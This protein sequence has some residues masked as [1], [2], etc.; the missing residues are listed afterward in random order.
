MAELTC[1][2]YLPKTLKVLISEETLQ[3]RIRALADELNTL[4]KDTEGLVLIGI[5]KGGFMFMADLVK[6]LKVPCEIEFVRLASYGDGHKTSGNVKAVDLT[7]PQLNG[8]DVLLIEDIVDTGLTLR[9][10]L[11]YLTSLHEPKSLR[12]A[13]L[14]DKKETRQQHVHIDF[15]GFEIENHYVIGYGLDDAGLYRN[16]PFIA[17]YENC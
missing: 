3:T 9:F 5:L 8:K 15:A 6:H 1:Y 12:L 13:V 7:L 11:D 2:P 17:Y 14:L 16:L 10:F 4:Y